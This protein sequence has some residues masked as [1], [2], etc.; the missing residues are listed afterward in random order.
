MSS[1]LFARPVVRFVVVGVLVGLVACGAKQPAVQRPADAEAVPA[2]GSITISISDSLEPERR[3]RFDKAEGSSRLGRAVE[4]ELTR[5]GRFNRESPRTLEVQVTRY[6]M[7]S[8][9]TVVWLGIM[10]G[11]DLLEVKVTARDGDRIVREYSTGAAS[12][13]AYKGLDQ[14]SRLENL[15]STL[16][17]RIVEE[18]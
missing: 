4:A 6:R 13:G 16:A 2:V 12:A 1:I 15:V 7:R 18:L 5:A 9:A 11:S 14:V 3:T 8:G 10:A 17:K